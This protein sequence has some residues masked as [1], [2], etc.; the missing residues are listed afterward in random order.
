MLL[1]DHELEQFTQT[2]VL[3]DHGFLIILHHFYFQCEGEFIIQR[4]DLMIVCGEPEAKLS[5]TLVRDVDQVIVIDVLKDDVVEWR[6]VGR[7]LRRT[8]R[9]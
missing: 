8:L 5:H 3:S 6:G 2:R 7:R 1:E 9:H 4:D